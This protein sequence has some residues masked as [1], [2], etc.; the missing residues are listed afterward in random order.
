MRGRNFLRII[1]ESL[2][3][4]SE[5]YVRYYKSLE[6]VGDHG[7]FEILSSLEYDIF[8]IAS[9]FRWRKHHAIVIKSYF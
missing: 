4:T 5:F 8:N 2:T 1:F 7:Y 3:H 9:S 6:M